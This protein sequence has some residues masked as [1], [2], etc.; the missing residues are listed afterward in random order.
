MIDIENIQISYGDRTLFKDLS[1]SFYGEDR[2]G[3]IGANGSGKST[4]LKIINGEIAPDKGKIS[5]KKD[6]KVGYIQQEMNYTESNLNVLNETL[7][8]F[9]D[10]LKNKTEQE[11]LEHLLHTLDEESED[12]QI[13]MSRYTNLRHEFEAAHGYDIEV[14]AKKVLFGLG[15]VDK[16]MERP[17]V[18]FSGG[19]RMRVE[20][21]KVLLRDPDILLLDEPTNHLEVEAIEWFENYLKN[22]KGAII[23]ISHDRYL[24][25]NIVKKVIEITPNGVNKYSGNYSYYESEHLLRK[26]IL[27]NEFKNQ[28]RKVQQVE[29]FIERFRAKNTKASQVQ[30]RIK[31]LEKLDRVEMIN[32]PTNINFRF[33]QPPSSGQVVMDLIDVSKSYGDIQVFDDISI[34]IEKGEKVGLVGL[35]GAGKST[36]AKII[37]AETPIDKGLRKV[38]HNVS[39]AYFAQHQS[40]YLDKNNT[41]FEEVETVATNLTQ[42]QLRSILGNFLFTGDDVFKKIQVL[43][44]G[45][46]SRVALAK[47]LLLT[48]NLLVFDEP[49]NHLDINSKKILVEALKNFEGTLVLVSHDRYVMDQLIEKTIEIENNCIKTYFGNYSYYIN[50]KEAEKETNL[51]QDTS[52]SKEKKVIISGGSFK[53]KEQKREEA[54]LRKAQAVKIKPLK[55]KISEVEKNISKLEELKLS[56]EN[57]LADPETYKDEKL[58]KDTT[59]S[60]QDIKKQLNELF[61]RWEEL[62]IEIEE[63]SELE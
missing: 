14:K 25:D 63:F 20:I 18:E 44:G 23:L 60:Y 6:V 52:V 58:L 24:L 34:K 46:K 29:R 56:I 13:I 42:S 48:A 62:N 47:V 43:S 30:S 37:A 33:P 55:N 7:H 3:I 26:E 61:V 59:Y 27:E 4:L 32:D 17:I 19:W 15:F 53:T 50:K 21:A 40:E 57:I 45:E 36:L 12:Y 1:I 2:V 10:L 28:Q 41:I 51:S 22:F 49:T 35:N 16:D 38:G 5:I 54:E 39:I 11:E 8:A 31:M 9:E